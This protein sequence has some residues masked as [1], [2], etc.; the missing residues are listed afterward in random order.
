MAPALEGVEGLLLD[1][2]GVIYVQDEA[3][4]GAAEALRSLREAGIPIRLVTNTWRP[5]GF[6]RSGHAVDAQGK[7]R[8]NA[9]LNREEWE[10]LDQEVFRM[11]QQQLGA[12]ADLI[13]ARLTSDTTLAEYLATWRVASERIP[14]EVSMD[15]RTRRTYDR[16]DKKTFGVPI[17]IISTA[18]EIG[19]WW[20]AKRGDKEGAAAVHMQLMAFMD[21][22]VTEAYR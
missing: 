12:Y 14:A 5:T 10:K 3:V 4:P 1:L 11:A 2:S 9:L 21:W 19:R 13:A 8:T 7:V 17:P 22:V 16:I 20:T 18:Y 6:T 15:L